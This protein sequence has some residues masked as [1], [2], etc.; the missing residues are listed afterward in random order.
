MAPAIEHVSA[1]HLTT[2]FDADS[3][4]HF[5]GLIMYWRCWLMT[6]GAAVSAAGISLSG[7]EWGI[8]AKGIGLV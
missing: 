5:R 3:S 2:G 1:S 7:M 8:V 4:I 6:A